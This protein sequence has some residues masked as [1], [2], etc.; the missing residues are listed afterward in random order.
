MS[1]TPD[2]SNP[3]VTD[4]SKRIS[5]VLENDQKDVISRG[6]HVTWSAASATWLFLIATPLTFFPRIL[7]LVFGSLLTEMNKPEA[8]DGTAETTIRTLNVLEINLAH[9]AGLACFALGTLIVIQSGAL[10]LT[11]SLSASDGVAQSSAA[12]PFRQPTIFIATAF[13]AILAWNSYDLNMKI[14]A[15][16]S[17]GL[18]VYGLWV[19]LFA[20]QGR[21]NQASSKASS[22]PFKNSAA[23]ESKAEKKLQ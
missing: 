15:A 19:L 20:H 12:A 9:F 1:I 18:T 16:P 11:S 8:L 14:A 3:S 21:V 7:N 2:S 6:A 10:P 13:F 23:E 5:S 17:A 22:F 4:P